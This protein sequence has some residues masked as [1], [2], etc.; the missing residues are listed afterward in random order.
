MLPRSG[1]RYP[2]GHLSSYAHASRIS[3]SKTLGHPIENRLEQPR[4]HDNRQSKRQSLLPAYSFGFDVQNGSPKG[5]KILGNTIFDYPL[6]NEMPCYDRTKRS[7][8]VELI[9]VPALGAEYTG[10]EIKAMKKN[11]RFSKQVTKNRNIRDAVCKLW[12]TE[13]KATCRNAIIFAFAFFVWYVEII[14]LAKEN[15]CI[16]QHWNATVFRYSKSS[17]YVNLS[18]RKQ[19]NRIS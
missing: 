17:R 12:K 3:A 5:S 8:G 4:S 10:D 16:F 9:T 14:E 2:Y 13:S 19:A 1:E 6:H 18:M 7:E 11:R 15:D